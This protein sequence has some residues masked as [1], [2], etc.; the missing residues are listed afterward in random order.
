MK[1]LAI[2]I[3]ALL[4]GCASHSPSTVG[5]VTQAGSGVQSPA[6]TTKPSLRELT[7]ADLQGAAAYAAKNGYP[8]RAAMWLAIE[9]QLTAA[10]NQVAA[11]KAAIAAVQKQT[12]DI[13][14]PL[15]LIEMGAEAVAQGIPANVRANCEPI[16]LP[17]HLLPVPRL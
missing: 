4:A 9:G 14:G 17:I 1:P 7:H 12:G 13:A 6:P 10:E 11:C 3:I 16:P 15:T 2:L 5:S 8:A